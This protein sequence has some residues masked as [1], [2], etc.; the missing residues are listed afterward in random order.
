MRLF[1]APKLEAQ[2]REQYQVV[3][4]SSY[5]IEARRLATKFA[6]ANIRRCLYRP[7]DV[8]WLYYDPNLTSRPAEKVMKHMLGGPNLG[9]I[10]SRQTQ[11]KWD[12][13][14]TYNLCGHKSCAAYDINSL[15]PLYLYE[16]SLSFDLGS[17]S[18]GSAH[19]LTKRPNFNT[20]FLKS[21]AAKLQL[22]KK[23]EHGLPAGLTPEDIF[24]Y[25]YAVFTVP[26]THPYAES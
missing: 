2:F 26:A 6:D 19:S 16:H 22:A 18:T 24:H 9:L 14:A 7:M 17:K 25:A 10:A 12:V 3:A 23:G 4:S 1:Y 11:E 5:D 21:L 15:F 8:R 20:S 13:L